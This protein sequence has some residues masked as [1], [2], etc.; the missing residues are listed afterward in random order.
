MQIHI[1]AFLNNDIIQQLN[2]V[3]VTERVIAWRILIRLGGH[4][5]MSCVSGGVFGYAHSAHPVTSF[6]TALSGDRMTEKPYY[7]CSVWLKSSW[8]QEGI[9]WPAAHNLTTMTGD[10]LGKKKKKKKPVEPCSVFT[11]LSEVS[12]RCLLCAD[13]F[14]VR[15]WR[16][17]VWLHDA[18]IHGVTLRGWVLGNE[19]LVVPGNFHQ[20]L[21]KS[22]CGNLG[23]L[24][25]IFLWKSSTKPL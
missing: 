24:A 15:D 3:H 21:T 14:I 19:I 5:G 22:S 7:S 2:L 6:S 1:V 20:I 16:W 17:G 10:K 18:I 9:C 4:A 11:R 13:R 12:Q 8:E 23:L 25:R